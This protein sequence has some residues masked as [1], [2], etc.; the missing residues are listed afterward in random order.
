MEGES[1]KYIGAGLAAFG[2]I[3]AGLGVG[4]VFAAYLNGVSRNPSVESKIKTLTFVGAAFAEILG[5]LGFVI[6]VMILYS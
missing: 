1:L 5:L 3:G 4:S 6:A 2:L